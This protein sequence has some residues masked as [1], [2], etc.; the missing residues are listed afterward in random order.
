M[1]TAWSGRFL[2][3]LFWLAALAFGALWFG[4]AARAEDIRIEK[5]DRLPVIQLIAA[6]Q[7]KRFLLDTAATSILNLRSFSSQNSKEISITSWRGTVGTSAR[8]VTITELAVASHRL[9]NLKLP[10]ID[11][12]PIS[13]ACGKQIDGI[14]G[15]DMIEA[16]GITVDLKRQVASLPVSE[17]SED[18]QIQEVKRDLDGCVLAFNRADAGAFGSCLD[19]HIA[20]FTIKGE[21]YGREQVLNYFQE[22]YFNVS[23][24]PSLEVNPRAFHLVG[25]AAWYDYDF[26]IKLPQET[27]QARGMAMCRKIDG[28]WRVVNMHH[29]APVLVAAS[30][31][32][33]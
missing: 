3:D 8:E 25:D 14:F 11:L 28:H 17:E 27:V 13:E 30:S 22:R 7:Q 5:C 2:R 9:H 12:S 31:S 15:A 20:L 4:Q 1:K 19:P 16:T 29:S 33:K 26:T 6:G 23:P 24:T 18:L 32:S 10:A 21:F